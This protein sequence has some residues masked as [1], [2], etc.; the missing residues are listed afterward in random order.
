MWKTW[1]I[2]LKL[3]TFP[4]QNYKKKEINIFEWDFV[5]FIL[6]VLKLR[7]KLWIRQPCA[8][9]DIFLNCHSKCQI[10]K[11]FG[12]LCLYFCTHCRFHWARPNNKHICNWLKDFCDFCISI[13]II[14]TFALSVFVLLW[15]K[16]SK[17]K[18]NNELRAK[19]YEYH[20]ISA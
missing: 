6:S 8:P 11:Y 4:K 20:P 1:N 17:S 14:F 5:H 13:T 10:C 9:S 2:F 18:K 16:L 19:I 7:I 12:V 15:Q 3:I